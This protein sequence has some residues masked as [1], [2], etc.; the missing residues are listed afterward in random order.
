[1]GKF[2]AFNG[3]APTTAG[4]L[5][6]STGTSI[7]T[8]QQLKPGA[9]GGIV[10]TGWGF[11]LDTEQAAAG[12]VELCKTDVAATVTAYATADIIALSTPTVAST[13]TKGTASSGYTGSGEGTVAA[14]SVYDVVLLPVSTT[15]SP[16]MTYVRK[17]EK[18]EQVYVPVGTFIRV[19]STTGTSAGAI[20]W[21]TWTE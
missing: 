14:A 3:P 5:K 15:A 1:M 16:A 7:K 20:C 2:K 21:I 19:R 8:L 18:H 4:Q 12:Q 9:G 10:I 6:V 17:F 11:S 13:L